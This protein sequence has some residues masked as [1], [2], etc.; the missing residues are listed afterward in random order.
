MLNK[1]H[2]YKLQFI[3]LIPL[4]ATSLKLLGIHFTVNLFCNPKKFKR[5]PLVDNL[6]NAR[7][8]L[9]ALKQ[10]V[11]TSKYNGSCLSRSIVLQRLLQNSGISSDIK[12]G[13][14]KIDKE[15]KAHAWV[16]HQEGPLNAGAK[17]RMRYQILESYNITNKLEFS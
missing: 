3:L 13:V 15:F 8:I 11:K 7:L 14:R 16:D 2:F 12:I 6:Q 4:V 9:R 5:V 10:A 17:V 1:H